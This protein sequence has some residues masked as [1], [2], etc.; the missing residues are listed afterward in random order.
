M[1]KNAI[2]RALRALTDTEQDDF[3]KAI[4]VSR[5]ILSMIENE[6][7]IVTDQIQKRVNDRLQINLDD[8][9]LLELI[10]IRDELS[11]AIKTITA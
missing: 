5:P 6:K 11:A 4:G 1:D 7:N 3:A 9:R 10:P 8:P 2:L